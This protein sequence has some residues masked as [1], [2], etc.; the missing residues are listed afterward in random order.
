M[1]ANESYSSRYEVVNVELF[2]IDRA[3][4]RMLDPYLTVCTH[5]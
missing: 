2:V 1:S 5:G 4:W 3:L